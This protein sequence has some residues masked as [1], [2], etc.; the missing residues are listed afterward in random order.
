MSEVVACAAS[1]ERG[2]WE[3]SSGSGSGVPP[4][5]GE[6]ARRGSEAAVTGRRGCEAAM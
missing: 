4:N 3:E 2:R 6:S 5:E 1:D